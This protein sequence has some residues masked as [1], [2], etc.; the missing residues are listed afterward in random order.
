MPA[1]KKTRKD[2]PKYGAD[3]ARANLGDLLNRAGFLGERIVITRHDKGVA[4]LVS[5]TDLARLEDAAA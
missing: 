4:A 2:P 1:T 5:M 3:E